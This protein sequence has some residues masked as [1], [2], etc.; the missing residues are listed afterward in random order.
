VYTVSLPVLASGFPSGISLHYNNHKKGLV[1]TAH[2]KLRPFQVCSTF[3]NT[4]IWK[5]PHAR[6]DS[7]STRPH[8]NC[9]SKTLRAYKYHPAVLA[10][11]AHPTAMRKHPSLAHKLLLCWG[12]QTQVRRSQPTI[13]SHVSRSPQIQLERILPIAFE[14][15]RESDGKLCVG[16]YYK[17]VRRS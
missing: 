9:G 5:E 3:T 16:R 7:N 12:E 2:N 14:I 8:C 11:A 4:P 6:W 1:V 13:T 17:V 10:T 15:F